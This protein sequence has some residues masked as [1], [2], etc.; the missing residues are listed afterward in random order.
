MRAYRLGFVILLSVILIGQA[1]ATVWQQIEKAKENQNPLFLLLTEDGVI[2]LDT[3]RTTIQDAAKQVDRSVVIELN[4]SD[5]A[6]APLVKQFRLASAPVPMILVCGANGVIAGGVPGAGATVKALV[7]M[8]PSPAKAE[9]LLALKDGKPVFLI[10][11]RH[12]ME[13]QAAVSGACEL[14]CKEMGDMAVTVIIDL[15]DKAEIAFLQ[16]LKIDPNIKHPVT[17]VFNVQ[18]NVT[19]SYVGLVEVPALVKSATQRTVSSCC[20]PGSG[21]SCAPKKK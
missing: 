21:K 17:K 11:G 15:D 20:P 3:I 8:V 14:A 6:N 12:G 16:Q 18:G 2:G 10:S 5:I 19:A 9:L 1:H 13:T 4:R 7:D